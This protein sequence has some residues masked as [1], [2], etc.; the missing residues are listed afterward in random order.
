LT[1]IFSTIVGLALIAS[2]SIMARQQDT[3]LEKGVK[4]LDLQT[5]KSDTLAPRFAE[6]SQSDKAISAL[7]REFTKQ[8]FQPQTG[9]E[10]YIGWEG[11]FQGPD[12]RTAKAAMIFQNYFKKDDQ[13][14]AAL[15]KITISSGNNSA[16]YDFF[17]IESG[18]S[19]AKAIEYKVDKSFN[20]VRANSWW[21]CVVNRVNSGCGSG[22]LQGFSSCGGP[23][24]AYIACVVGRCFCVIGAMICCGCNCTGWCSWFSGCCRQ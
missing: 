8:G 15:G 13:Q 20:V 4:V 18:G 7:S 6:L 3:G 11:Q 14:Q 10:D 9:A 21:S 2:N 19:F 5:L 24:Y 22:C 23:W 1:K 16:S 17:L 12:G